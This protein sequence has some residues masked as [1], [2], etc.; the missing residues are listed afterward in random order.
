M[1]MKDETHAQASHLI[2]LAKLGAIAV[3]LIW[4]ASGLALYWVPDRGT[5]G[6]M[7]G[8]VNALFSGLAFL[9]VVLAIVLQYE[10]LKEQ[11]RE[12]QQS[13]IAQEETARALTAQLKLSGMRSKIESLNL[14]IE[15]KSRVLARLDDRRTVAESDLR[16]KIQRR[17]EQYE[18]ELERI[19]GEEINWHSTST[20]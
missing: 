5:F 11:R 3:A 16:S 12:I 17:I 9:G 18:E 8:A 20:L 10:E 1:K 4:L 19:L 14:L 6:D 15:A 2:R 7:F 13:R